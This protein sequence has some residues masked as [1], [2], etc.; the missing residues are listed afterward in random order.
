MKPGDTVTIFENSLT[1]DK[2]EGQAKLVKCLIED[3]G[4]AN[5]KYWE[6]EFT[7]EPGTT[8]QRWVYP[9]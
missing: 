8:R 4:I 9:S 6:V 2:P 3:N 7:E 5:Y 1:H